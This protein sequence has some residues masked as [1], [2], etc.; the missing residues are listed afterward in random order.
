MSNASNVATVEDTTNVAI[1]TTK[2]I[3]REAA[4]TMDRTTRNALRMKVGQ[5]VRQGDVYI[6][7]LADKPEFNQAVVDAFL[8]Q[9]AKREYFSTA[10]N[11]K[12]KEV[13]YT[14]ETAQ[15]LKLAPGEN[16][17]SRHEV[18]NPA[19][20][21]VKVWSPTDRTTCE[22]IGDVLVIERDSLEA[23]V[24]NPVGVE[25]PEHADCI[26][27][28]GLYITTYQADALRPAQRVRD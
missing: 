2:R 16:Q 15:R 12:F 25:H 10:T 7:K 23:A 4:K 17:G 18:P 20:S 8:A 26:L 3:E 9:C 13:A 11:V 14:P 27:G 6:T 5:Y 22:L 21:G 1:E 19:K 28:G 24:E